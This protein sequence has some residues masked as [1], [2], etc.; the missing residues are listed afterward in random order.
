MWFQEILD[1]N[2]WLVTE[3][4]FSKVTNSQFWKASFCMGR[5]CLQQGSIIQING[6]LLSYLKKC[7]Y[8]HENPLV[9][10]DRR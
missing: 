2:N 5:L 1:K 8:M 6:T 3:Q 4:W 9:T 7:T 10:C